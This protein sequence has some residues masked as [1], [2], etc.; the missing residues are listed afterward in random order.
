MRRSKPT[1]VA[2]CIAMSLL[3]AAAAQAEKKA[4]KKA[5]KVSVLIVT[6][7]DVG[8]HKWQEASS[9]TA[10]ILSKSGRF[11]V[12]IAESLDVLATSALKD[13]DVLV[14]NYGFWKQG[15]PSDEGKAGLLNYV[16][17]GKGVVALHFA[18]SS[19]Q[20]WDEYHELIGRWWQKGK[21]G[22]GPFGKF[23][24]NVAD[25]EHPIAKGIKDFET[26]D[27]LYA[28]LSGDAKI[29]VL[30]TAFSEWSGKVEPIIFSKPYGKGRVVQNVLGHGPK[31]RANESYQ[32]LICRCTEWAATGSVTVD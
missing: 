28:K 32:K 1:A 5:E 14:L 7:F 30:A 29:H 27:E 9:E 3:C 23:T 13:Y 19:F 16:K 4:E 21:G 10:A 20:E 22:H 8:S 6:G 15:G 18:C 11:D 26:S 25:K 12:K 17:G 2:L 31:A 24:V